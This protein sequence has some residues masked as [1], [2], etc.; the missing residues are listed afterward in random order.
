MTE[1]PKMSKQISA[2]AGIFSHK[3]ITELLKGASGEGQSNNPMRAGILEQW[4][5]R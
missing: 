1:I 4:N 2:T 3:Q 5:R